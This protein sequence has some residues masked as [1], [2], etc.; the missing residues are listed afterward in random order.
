MKPFLR[1]LG[2]DDGYFKPKTKSKTLLVGVVYRFGHRVEGIIS[3]KIS[4]DGFD[5][6]QKIIEMAKKTKFSG[7]ISFLILSGINFAGFN[8]A[9]IKKIYEK[10]SLPLIIVFRKKP[11]FEK[12]ENALK[13]I[14]FTK[15]RLML[16]GQGG[17]ITAFKS[18]FFQCYACTEAEA[19]TVLRKTILHSSLPEPVRL[20][21]LIASGI[22]IGESTRP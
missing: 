18:I 6:T 11:R 8:I 9:D 7:Q 15:K 13:K 20:A 4:V 17:K 16:I 5:S 14:S 3:K 1:V 21:H 22:T 12:I 2:I 10:T 19:K